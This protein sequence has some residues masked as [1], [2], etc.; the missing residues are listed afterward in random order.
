MLWLAAADDMPAQETLATLSAER[1]TH[2]KLTPA[3]I[4]Q[5]FPQFSLENVEFGIFEPQSGVLLARRAVTAVLEEAVRL[6]VQYRIEAAVSPNQARGKLSRLLTR[7]GEEFSAATFV[8]ACGAW[9]AG[10]FPNLLNTRIF[11]T[12]QEV[13]YFGTPPGAKEFLPGAMPTW[14]HRTDDM[15]G[16][17]DVD[18]R[19]IKLAC[20][21][22]GPPADPDSELRVV[23]E[24]GKIEAVKYVRRR[25]PALKDAPI[26]E[27]RVC[28]Y[29]NTW[30][31]DLLLDRHPDWDNVWIAGGG[32][33]HGFKHGPSVG[34]Y[35]SGR[36]LNE[37]SAEPRFSFI[38]KKERQERAVY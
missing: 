16:M 32:S 28:Q 29:E 10:L 25:L 34:E 36:I 30:N 8:F 18:N 11:P 33:G 26:V 35:L 38:S 17:P 4:S 19:G 37:I 22:H 20:D 15:Y 1:I 31:G 9:L 3:E 21:R 7:G 6:G 12:R 13:F 5:R 14:L 2:E 23:S 24:T 27:S